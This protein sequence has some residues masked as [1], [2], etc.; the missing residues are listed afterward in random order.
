MY[1][2][3]AVMAIGKFEGRIPWM[4]LDTAGNVTVG[5]G[6]MIANA[7][8]AL[9]FPFRKANGELANNQDI[10]REF[11]I[12]HAMTK[13]LVAQ[14]Y[15]RADSLVLMEENINQIFRDT[16]A[17]CESEIVSHFPEFA[18]FPDAAKVALL[19]MDYNLGLTNLRNEFPR[20]CSAVLTNRWLLASSQ[21]RRAGQP[22]ARNQWTAEN[23]LQAGQRSQ[24][25]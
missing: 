12:V 19:D 6:Q 24:A 5:I 22:E 8:D 3:D 4:Y 7:G 16:L 13:G 14:A 9:R 2:D 15:K 11:A 18:Q 10:E 20:F 17:R 25:Q 23:F 1:L 21:C